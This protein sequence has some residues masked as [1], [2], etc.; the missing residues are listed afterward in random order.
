VGGERLEVGGQVEVFSWWTSGGEQEALNAV[1]TEHQSL[2]PEAKV[3]NASVE[4]AD[5]AREQLA[6]RFADGFPPDLFQANMG[7]DLYGW[8]VTNGQNDSQSYVENLNDL[9][10]A[11]NWADV[12]D[13]EVLDSVTYDGNMYGVPLNV[14]RIN[15]LYYRIDLF[16]KYEL[17]PPESLED[18]LDLCERISSDDEL[19][20][21]APGGEMACLALGN[22]W[23][24]TIS[25]LTFEMLLPA[26]AGPDY[27]EDYFEGREEALS[28][29]IRETLSVALQLYCGGGASDN[30]LENTWFNSDVNDVTWDEGVKKLSEGKALMAPMGDWAKGFLESEAGGGLVAG[31]DFGVIPFPGTEGTFVFT[32]DTFLL[33]KGAANRDGAR[34]LL[35]TFGSVEG[36]LAFNLVKGSIPARTDVEPSQFDEMQQQT[37]AAFADAQK[38]RAL[39]GLLPAN[40]REPL[41]PELTASLKTGNTAIIEGFLEANYPF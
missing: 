14:H 29:E 30:C 11:L 19:Q 9:S 1:I 28:N 18:L 16:D 35:R 23:N 4:Y 8:V 27:Y 39:S 25:L 26:I 37:M 13:P 3:T 21:A 31:K 24:W 38:V 15:A 6:I 7:E 20:A 5:K 22:K 2:V 40:S 33:P 34:S 36:Q 10:E 41:H 17:Q 32:A 12:F